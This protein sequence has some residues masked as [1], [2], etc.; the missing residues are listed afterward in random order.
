ML[1]LID[2]NY[3]STAAVG[4]QTECMYMYVYLVVGWL[5]A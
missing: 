2:Y 5:V 3:T 4:E 1:I